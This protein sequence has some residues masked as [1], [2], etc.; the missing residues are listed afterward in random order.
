MFKLL[1][2]KDSIIKIQDLL[3][4]FQLSYNINLNIIFT[5]FIQVTV[6]T[7]V[8]YFSVQNLQFHIYFE[9]YDKNCN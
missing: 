3:Q 4:I 7:N 5:D 8:K 6:F 2:I 9:H 1:V